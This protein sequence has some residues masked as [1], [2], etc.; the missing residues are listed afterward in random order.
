[1][2]AYT[3]LWSNVQAGP[4]PLNFAVMHRI[5]NAVSN[6]GNGGFDPTSSNVDIRMSAKNGAFINMFSQTPLGPNKVGAASGW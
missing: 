3:S 5:V 4:L 1:M 6:G 2:N